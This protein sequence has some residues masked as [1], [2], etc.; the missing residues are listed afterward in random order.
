MVVKM[1]AMLSRFWWRTWRFCVGLSEAA[2]TSE[3]P[4]RVVMH[5][6]SGDEKFQRAH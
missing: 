6:N 3:D 5:L 1:N 2:G 4:H